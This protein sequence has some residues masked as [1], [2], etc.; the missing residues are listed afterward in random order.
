MRIFITTHICISCKKIKKLVL[1]TFNF[2]IMIFS[3]FKEYLNEIDYGIAWLIK[4]LKI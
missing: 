4:V 2:V 3:D 1:I